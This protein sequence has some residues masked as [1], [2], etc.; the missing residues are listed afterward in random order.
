[1]TFRAQKGYALWLSGLPGAGKTTVSRALQALLDAHGVANVLLDGDEVRP[2]I[3][4]HLGHSAADR[5]QSLDMYIRLSKLMLQ[6]KV[7]VIL[8]IINHSAE[9]RAIAKAAHPNDQFAQ[10][11]IDTPLET[12][13]ARDPKGLYEKAL[14]SSSP[15]NMVGVDIDYESADDADV[16]IRTAEETPDQAAE[17]I[18]AFLKQTVLVSSR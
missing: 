6:N 14:S 5:R 18:F 10:V 17:R 16:I 12:C 4:G 2:I 1:M 11:W 13:R 7:V 15:G 8:A 9:Q 3:C